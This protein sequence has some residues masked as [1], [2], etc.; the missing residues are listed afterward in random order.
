MSNDLGKR[1]A[2][3]S[4]TCPQDTTTIIGHSPL[5]RDSMKDRVIRFRPDCNRGL[6]SLTH[7]FIGTPGLRP[8]LLP[9]LWTAAGHSGYSFE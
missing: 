2:G 7:R 6:L 3:R 9:I 8:R 4:A 1:G 5:A